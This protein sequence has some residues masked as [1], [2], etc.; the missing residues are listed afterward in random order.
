M[1][2]SNTATTAMMLPIVDGIYQVMSE[3]ELE[4]EMRAEVEMQA[5]QSGTFQKTMNPEVGLSSCLTSNLY[6]NHSTFHLTLFFRFLLFISKIL[7][8]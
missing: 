3:Q 7:Q 8:P 5:L 6:L 2:I 4:E 1:W